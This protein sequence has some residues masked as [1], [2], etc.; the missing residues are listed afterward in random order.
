MTN[1]QIKLVHVAVKE[2]GI[3]TPQFDGRYRL[4]LANYKQPW[5]GPVRS[6]TQ[7]DNSQ[8]ED[9]LA[10]CESHGWRMPG[11]PEDFYRKKVAAEYGL[12][13]FAARS[14]IRHMAKDLGWTPEHLDNFARKMTG[15]NLITIDELKPEE[16]YKIIEALKVIFNRNN[17]T[18]CKTLKEIKDEATPADFNRNRYAGVVVTDGSNQS[19]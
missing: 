8:L 2:A 9:L 18:S 4:L 17:G 12:A 7:L 14:G 15:F 10:I 5:G 3:R 13:S 1:D 11:K 6:C 16:A 19:E